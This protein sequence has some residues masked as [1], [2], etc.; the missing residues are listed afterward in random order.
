MGRILGSVVDPSSPRGMF[1]TRL[2]H[3]AGDKSP[4]E[5]ANRIGCT[6][7]TVRKYLTGKRTPDLNDWPE[8]AKAIGLKRWQDLLPDTRRSKNSPKHN[9]IQTVLYYVLG[10]FL[11]SKTAVFCFAPLA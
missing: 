1:A 6:P 2:R 7:D 5:L 8:I 9:T 4:T 10:N 3:L 11:V